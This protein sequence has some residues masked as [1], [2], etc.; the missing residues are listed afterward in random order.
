M[1]R[2]LKFKGSDIE[3]LG[4]QIELGDKLPEFTLTGLDMAD[5]SEQG[6]AGKT[7]VISVVPS[8]DTPV[9]SIQ[10]KKFNEKA[11]KL[12]ADVVILTVSR[13]L[14]F[15]QKRWCGAEGVEKL[16][17]ASDYKYRVFGD[18][19]GVE[20][21]TLGLLARAVFVFNKEGRAV[22]VEY[23]DE[24]TSEPNYDE[25]VNAISETIA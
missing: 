1:G 2:Y 14:P 6:F 19:F 21:P 3:V 20:L 4:N 8:L 10:T 11:S 24:V 15:A 25:A 12:G 22:Y 5:I 16:T 23:V 18:S 17:L 13:D 7:L 9:C